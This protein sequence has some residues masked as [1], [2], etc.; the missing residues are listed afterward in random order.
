MI[1]F[2]EKSTFFNRE[3]NLNLGLFFLNSIISFFDLVFFD[4]KNLDVLNRDL[5][6]KGL[7]KLF[8][9]NR[10]KVEANYCI[11]FYLFNKYS[12]DTNNNMISM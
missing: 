12:L 3:V 1:S 8:Y 10:L 4:L 5:V 7:V 2:L 6:S 11:I 9:V